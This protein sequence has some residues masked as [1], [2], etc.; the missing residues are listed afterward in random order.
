VIRE[1]GVGRVI[2]PGDGG[3]LCSEI[4]RYRSDPEILQEEGKR[5]SF[6]PRG[7]DAVDGLIRDASELLARHT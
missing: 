6:L 2:P 4:L 3:S 5:A 7:V 1:T